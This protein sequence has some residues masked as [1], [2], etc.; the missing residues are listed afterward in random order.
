MKRNLW[1]YAIVSYFIVFITGIITGVSFAMRHDDQLVRPDYYE[2]EIK[3]QDQ[4]DRIART[5][6][7]NTTITYDRSSQ[8]LRIQLPNTNIIGT[9][10]LYRPSNGRLDKKFT[11]TAEPIDVSTLEPGLWKVRLNW[12][13]SGHEYYFEK[14]VVL[15]SN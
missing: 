1:P 14:P 8:S 6:R 12:I 5:D 2:H 15:Y 7:S 3:Y 10:H 4:I 9:V 13:L 11:L